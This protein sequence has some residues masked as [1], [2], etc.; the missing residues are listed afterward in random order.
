[1]ISP[2]QVVLAE[3]QAI[4][5]DGLRLMLES[6]ESHFSIVAEAENGKDALQQASTL[7]PDLILLDIG[8]P[9]FN[10]T[11]VLPEIKRRSPGTKVLMITQYD[12]EEYVR[13]ALEAGADG[14][15]IKNDGRQ[16]LLDAIRKVLSGEIYLSPRIQKLLNEGYCS[17]APK[18]SKNPSI[19]K[20]SRQERTVIKLVAEGKRNKEI[21]E[22]LS[23]S[24]RT[25][26]KYR[27]R[28]LKKLALSNT[29]ELMKYA[30]EHHLV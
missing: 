22:L 29:L 4:V 16:A 11:E 1:M 18:L 28:I 19:D 30:L 27:S 17:S 25:V 6:S 15:F 12:T 2:V 7:K 5:R 21:A 8:M 24:E 23:L 13:T 20:L 26:E 3:D 9:Y 14:Y 10:G